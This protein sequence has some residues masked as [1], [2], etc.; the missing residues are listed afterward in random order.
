MLVVLLCAGP[1]MHGQ[2][3]EN[4]VKNLNSYV[5]VAPEASQL[6]K[7]IDYPVNLFTGSPTV[8]LP[9]YTVEGK[10]IRVPLTLNYQACGGVKV[11]EPASECGLGFVLSGPGQITREVRGTPDEGGSGAAGLLNN[12]HP[13]SYYLDLVNTP[14]QHLEF[15]NAAMG[16]LDLEP[17]LFYF[18]FGN[19]SGKFMY[20]EQKQKYECITQ[21][22]IKIQFSGTASASAFIITDDDGATYYFDANEKTA[23]RSD[24]VSVAL[25]G[26]IGSPMVT[27]W[28]LS[29]IVNADRTD[30]IMLQYTFGNYSF[31]ASGSSTKYQPLTTPTAPNTRPNLN[32]F[33][34]TNITGMTYLSKICSTSDTVTFVRES[35]A[36][37]DMPP[38]AY[39]LSKIIAGKGQ[40]LHIYKLEHSYFS[41]P[42]FVGTPFDQ[43]Y[44]DSS[45][46]LTALADYGNSEANTPIRWRFEYD[47][48]P[49]P[50]R[51]SYAQDFY[52][53]A[54][55][56]TETTLVPT[57]WLITND[58]SPLQASGANR[59][60]DINKMKAGIL[61]KIVYPTGGYTTFEYEPN[62]VAQPTPYSTTNT[63]P[64]QQLISAFRGANQLFST[65]VDSYKVTF[66]VLQN[67]DPAI[68]DNAPDSGVLASIYVNP[69]FQPTNTIASIDPTKIYFQLDGPVSIPLQWGRTKVHLKNGT[70]TLS[71]KNIQYMNQSSQIDLIRNITCA[72]SY[73]ILDTTNGVNDYYAGGLRIKSISNVDNMG[74]PT[75]KKE[76]LYADPVTDSS[77]GVFV[78][79]S[80][81]T[82]IDYMVSMTGSQ[83]E[84][85]APVA[86]PYLV[87]MGNCIMAGNNIAGSSV[88]YP[89]VIEQQRNG[90]AIVRTVHSFL[91]IRPTYPN[92][93]PYEP[94]LYFE[95]NQGLPLKTEYKL[96]TTGSAFVNEKVQ[97]KKYN[98]SPLDHNG[99]NFGYNITGVRSAL[100]AYNYNAPNQLLAYYIAVGYQTSTD[101]SYLISDSTYD[102]DLT[103]GNAV[104]TTW[105]NYTYGELNQKPLIVNTGSSDG[106]VNTVKTWYAADQ[107]EPSTE[108]ASSLTDPMTAANRLTDVIGTK[109]FKNGQLTGQ[110]FLYSHISGGKLL[111]DSIRQAILS[112]PLDKEAEV[113][114]YDSKA[115]PTLIKLRG[116]KYRRYLWESNRDL[117]LATCVGQNSPF[118]FTSFEYA[119]EQGTGSSSAL[120]GSKVYSFG[121]GPL[122]YT[123]FDN[124]IPVEVYL[125]STSSSVTTNSLAMTST[126]RTSGA[127][128][129]YKAVVSNPASITINGS[130]YIDQLLILPVGSD[131]DGNVFDSADRIIA[132]V[133]GNSVTTLFQYDNFGR[134]QKIMDE[135]GRILKQ[136]DYQYQGAQ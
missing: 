109:T 98:Y 124:S 61:N 49:L 82:Y 94:P 126:G 37:A 128:T 66:T 111:T 91:P 59:L 20:S 4:Y 1:L 121:S 21:Q 83:P 93:Y 6:M 84:S 87:R 135:E 102:Y 5:Q 116:G 74:A 16:Q 85:T 105:N 107:P 54:N 18:N 92:R 122:S 2:T 15:F 51:L 33:N 90:N 104:T 12:P 130:S 110:Q 11:D 115:N 63:L 101:R 96:N 108:V 78:A 28:K 24:C 46:Q 71:T 10:G 129:L 41:R 60:T 103:N 68:N 64:V 114:A 17:D 36:R 89:K 30:S 3:L 19:R 50:G 97:V 133:K 7:A 47:P 100:T 99:D 53:Y 31:Y 26:G 52:G 123:G 132:K 81:N 79:P 57:M 75:V 70:Y 106:S 125:W 62:S 119:G 73:K 35:T 117:P 118:V 80:V 25:S 112:N 23:T 8:S 40:P 69:S 134:L 120:S 14:G 67:P 48:T 113:L 39:A 29:K 32:C 136:N 55:G 88:I 9:L 13:V 22:P 27:S 86:Y 76:F 44:N 42:Q 95:S 56:N 58:G 38:G 77:Y 34:Y 65:S 43:I 72:I 127:W 45:L 131:F